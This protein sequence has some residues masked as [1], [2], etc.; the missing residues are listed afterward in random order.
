MLRAAKPNRA[1]LPRTAPGMPPT[2]DDVDRILDVEALSA[3]LAE[4]EAARTPTDPG[5]SGALVGE[6]RRVST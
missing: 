1:T 6:L 2:P 4:L 3:R 5:L